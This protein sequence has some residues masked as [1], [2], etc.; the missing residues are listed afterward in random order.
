LIKAASITEHT[1]NLKNNDLHLLAISKSDVNLQDKS[2]RVK[3]FTEME[4]DQ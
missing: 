3:V 2:L 4:N 1:G